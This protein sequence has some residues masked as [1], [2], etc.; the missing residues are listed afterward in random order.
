MAL[1]TFIH[2]STTKTNVSH[3]KT[4]QAN[5]FTSTDED[6][7]KQ[8]QSGISLQQKYWELRFSS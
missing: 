8:L 6:K 1:V 2:P 7:Y 3:V 5:D 4:L